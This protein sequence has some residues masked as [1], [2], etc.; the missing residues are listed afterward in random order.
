MLMFLPRSLCK[1]IQR[2]QNAAA[3]FLQK[4]DSEALFCACAG[5]I[6]GVPLGS[7]PVRSRRMQGWGVGVP[8]GPTVSAGPT[9][10]SQQ[11]LPES[12]HWIK[13]ARLPC[14][15]SSHGMWGIPGALWP[16]ISSRSVA[17][18]SRKGPKA[19]GVCWQHPHYLGWSVFSWIESGR[20]I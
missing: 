14:S 13:V 16:Q 10:S 2:A 6:L 1:R 3:C 12:P 11:G 19:C 18:E 8:E 4:A 15:S 5:R 7:T 20:H 17:E 9:G